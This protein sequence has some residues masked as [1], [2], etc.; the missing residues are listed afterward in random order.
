MT[1]H[2]NWEIE[3]AV[4]WHPREENGMTMLA[5]KCFEKL[6]ND[7]NKKAEAI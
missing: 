5:Y 7:I 4:H 6:Q 3:R 1:A 2:H